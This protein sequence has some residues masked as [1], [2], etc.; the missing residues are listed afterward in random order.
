MP[1]CFVPHPCFGAVQVTVWWCPDIQ[2]IAMD[3]PIVKPVRVWDLPTRLFHWALVLCVVTSVIAAKI[4]GAAMAWHFRSGY[5]ILALLLFRLVWGVMGGRWSRFRSFLYAP[6]TVLRYLKGQTQA[7]E[8]LDVGHNPLG[9]F[10]VFAI[11]GILILQV[12]TGLLADDEIASVG[13]LNKFVSN[14]IAV[15]ATGWHKQWGQ[16]FIFLLVATHIGAI[17]FYA[18]VK[19]KNLVKPMLDGDKQLPND[20]PS[21]DDNLRTRLWALALA[22]ICAACALAV[23]RLG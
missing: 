2:C 6:A 19:K 9:S 22:L 18:V 1:Q 10:S 7:H 21:S 20:T 13:P 23:M 15:L 4:G 17:A 16:W 8:H 14:A 3:T 5:V 11:I 12:A